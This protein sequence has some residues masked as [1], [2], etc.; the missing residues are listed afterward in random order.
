M[1]ITKEIVR[2]TEKEYRAIN[3][4]LSYSSIK[5]FNSNR[6][7]FYKK[8]ILGEKIE[9]KTNAGMVMGNLVDTMLL[10]PELLDSR[11]SINECAAPKGQVLQL[12]DNLYQCTLKYVKDGVCEADFDL[13][14]QEA[15]DICKKEDLFKGKDLKKVLELFV[16]PDKD[17]IIPKDYYNN[18]RNNFE[19]ITVSID[20]MTIAEKICNSLKESPYTR[21]YILNENGEYHNQLAIEFEVKGVKMKSLLDKVKIDHEKK[22][23]TPLDLKVIYSLEEFQWQYFD[24]EYWIQLGVY[25]LALESWKDEYFPGYKV[26]DFE[27]I[28]GESALG[29]TPMI[30]KSTV[31]NLNQAL[32]G[33]Y[34]KNGNF[35]KGVYELINEIAWHTQTGNWQESYECNKN[36]GK[37]TLTPF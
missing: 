10:Q 1:N 32:E 15:F 8:F 31:L 4:K 19:K 9:E 17:G 2:K 20:T 16:T 27:F 28:V 30:Y 11:Y 21:E 22:E 24:K 12:C 18:C 34:L 14:F 13:I 26:M 29:N 37:I 7:K 23:I 36:N 6:K 3:D 33:F 25:S 35:Q 5:M